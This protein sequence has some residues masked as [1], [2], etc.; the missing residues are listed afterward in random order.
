MLLY[1]NY[2]TDVQK[3]VQV[4]FLSDT[5]VEYQIWSFYGIILIADTHTHTNKVLK[6][7]I[8]QIQER[9]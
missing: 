8:F 5:N 9:S 7:V 3:K 1:E 6:N 4:A 2:S